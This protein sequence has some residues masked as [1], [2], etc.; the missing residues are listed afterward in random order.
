MRGKIG[1]PTNFP[2]NNRPRYTINVGAEEAVKATTEGGEE[3]YKVPIDLYRDG[4]TVE[5]DLYLYYQGQYILC[6]TKGVKW[7]KSDEERLQTFGATTFFVR[8]RSPVEHHQFLDEKLKSLLERPG[9]S[10]ERKASVLYDVSDPILSKV[11]TSPKESENIKSAASYVKNC[12]KFLNE[13]GSLTELVNLANHNL[14]E[15]THALH[16]STYAISLAKRM[17][18]NSYEDI[19]AIGM[20]ALLHDVGKSKIDAKILKKPGELD[21]SEWMMIRKHPEFG[22]ELLE[23]RPEVPKVARR[24]VLEHHERVNGRGYPKG[25]RNIHQFSKIVGIADVFNALTSETEYSKAMRPY[26][27]LKYIVQYMSLEFDKNL[28]AAFIEMLSD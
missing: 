22:Y 13:K 6:K 20:G 11:Y 2:E 24:I 1:F 5:T 28:V 7:T 19:F 26:E 17:G 25:I 14:T 15:H 12:I 21:D 3:Y 8:F 27:A 4:E 18:A 23:N 16:V 9:V 10:I